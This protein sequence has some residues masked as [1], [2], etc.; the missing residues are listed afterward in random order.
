MA[1]RADK[2]SQPH[3]SK[4][5]TEASDLCRD[6]PNHCRFVQAHCAS[7]VW[8]LLPVLFVISQ[9]TMK[10]SCR[11]LPLLLSPHQHCHIT[12]HDL[13]SIA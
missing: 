3:I 10:G 9:P 6:N 11:R 5:T 13:G 8:T 2:I 1:M 4:V 7:L 12:S